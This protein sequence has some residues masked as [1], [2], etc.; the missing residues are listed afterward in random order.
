MARDNLGRMK[1]FDQIERFQPG[2]V[3][4]RSLDFFNPA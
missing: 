2:L 1:G 4:L 3:E